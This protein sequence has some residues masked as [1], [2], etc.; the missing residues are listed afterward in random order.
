MKR[1]IRYV[2]YAAVAIASL[3]ILLFVLFNLPV[4]T[5]REDVSL[6][7]T[8]SYRYAEDLGL[9]PK[10]TL[11]AQLDDLHIQK[12]RIPVYWDLVEPEKGKPDYTEVDWQLSLIAERQGEVIL[13]IGQR[14]PRWPECHIPAWAKEDSVL[15]EQRLLAHL[16]RTVERYKYRSEIVMWQVE[17]EPFLSQFGECPKLDPKF[18]EQEIALVKTLDPTRPVLVTDSG[19]LSLWVRAAKRGDVFGTTLYRHIYTHNFG[20]RYITYPLSPSFFIIKTFAVKLFT[21]QENFMVIELQAEPWAPGFVA[22]FPLEEQFK[23]MNEDKLREN[24]VY[25]RKLGFP[26]IY[27]WGGEWWY[28]L[29]ERKGY[30]GLWEAARDIF[31]QAEQ[32]K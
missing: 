2:S 20:G 15:R 32:V 27:L 11:E 29:K 8:F 5:A 21:E 25:A 30:D 10:E 3:G 14:V 26:V 9:D 18:L 23:T 24:V 28:Y 12:W 7:M 19:E 13:S 1:S 22:S 6:G 17:N 16:E 4:G 31:A